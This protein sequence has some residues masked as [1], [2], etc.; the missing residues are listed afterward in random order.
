MN[1]IQEAH[2]IRR[3]KLTT[4]IV[5]VLTIIAIGVGIVFWNQGQSRKY[6]LALADKNNG[7]YSDA[8]EAFRELG[9]YRDSADQLSA[10]HYA[11]GVDYLNNGDYDSAYSEF[12]EAGDFSDA[13]SLAQESRYRSGV[14]AMESGNFNSARWDFSSLGNYKDAEDLLMECK[15]QEGLSRY[16][17]GDYEGAYSIWSDIVGYRDVNTYLSTDARN[18]FEL[19]A[20]QY[21]AYGMYTQLTD[22]SSRGVSVSDLI[23]RDFDAVGRNADTVMANYNIDIS[24]DAS[25]PSYSLTSYDSSGGLRFGIIAVINDSRESALRLTDSM[26]AEDTSDDT[27]SV[28]NCACGTTMVTLIGFKEQMP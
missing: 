1:S 25:S 21:N 22:W 8:I 14:A 17:S 26:N 15:Y 11:I 6:E 27:F 24:Y 13:S 12:S 2:A 10:C 19:M 9:S 7:K 5:V 23:E 4:L 16:N 3:R 18:I 28:Y 20:G